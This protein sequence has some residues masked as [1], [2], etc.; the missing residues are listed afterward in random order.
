[1]D[2]FAFEWGCKLTKFFKATIFPIIFSF[3]F[4]FANSH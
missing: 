3:N 1:M 4:P 2:E